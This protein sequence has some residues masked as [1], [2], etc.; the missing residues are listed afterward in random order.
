MNLKDEYSKDFVAE[1]ASTVKKEYRNFNAE[2]FIKDVCESGWGKRELKDRV[3]HMST[4][5]NTALLK[6]SKS[7]RS[8]PALKT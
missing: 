5:L 3:R 6:A 2:K 8:K 1:F 7:S 4:T